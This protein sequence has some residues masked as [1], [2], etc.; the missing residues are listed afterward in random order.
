MRRA[1]KVRKLGKSLSH[2][3]PRWEMG[4]WRS[5]FIS[6]VVLSAFVGGPVLLPVGP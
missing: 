6:N 1:T 4:R 5:T 2:F 3:R